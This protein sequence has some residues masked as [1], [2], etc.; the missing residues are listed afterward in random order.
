MQL[1][2]SSTGW[3]GR[4]ETQAPQHQRPGTGH[5]EANPTW[6]CYPF[7]DRTDLLLCWG[8][9]GCCLRR[10]SRRH[11]CRRPWARTRTPVAPVLSTTSDSTTSTI[12]VADEIDAVASKVPG[13]LAAYTRSLGR[14]L[15]ENMLQ[16]NIVTS[17]HFQGDY[18]MSPVIRID[19]EVL[20]E[21]QSHAVRWGLVFGQPNQV[22][23]R[24]LGLDVGR[25]QP[26]DAQP[27]SSTDDPIRP[28]D[29][30]LGAESKPRHRRVTGGSLLRE[31]PDLPQGFRPYSDRDGRFY[32][33]PTE[34]P[35]ILFDEGGYVILKTEQSMLD[36]GQY[37]DPNPHSR[38]VHV[39]DG[40]SSA[41]GY[42]ACP[43]H[44]RPQ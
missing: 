8:S 2:R 37:L 41:P 7:P 23:R 31:H 38:K 42:V 20:K 12:L 19:D 39:R 28:S 9:S 18:M 33:W 10:S 32:E 17:C 30:R 34:F 29:V 5:Q 25:D 44:H 40:I 36:A 27:M 26:K 24:M 13:F 15:T 6:A 35:A 3:D 4:Q 43:H 21:L 16:G 1:L 22:L 11:P 14:N